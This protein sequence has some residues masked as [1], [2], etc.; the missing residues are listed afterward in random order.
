MKSKLGSIFLLLAATFCVAQNGKI[1]DI[2]PIT[3][4]NVSSAIRNVL[5]N[6]GY[7][8]LLD[9]KPFCQIWL[10]KGLPTQAKK[11]ATGAVYPQLTESTLVGVISF[12]Q[13]S[14]DYRGQAIAAGTY[15][16]R[17]ELIPSDGNHLGVSPNPDFLLLIPAGSDGD[18]NAVYKFDELVNLSRKATGTH[19]PAP[20]SMVQATRP[21]SAAISKDEED[22]WIFSATLKLASGGDL[23]LGLVVKG[24]ALQ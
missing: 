14:A 1:E 7:R 3:D 17:Y 18:P 15:T 9:G 8:A 24:T 6:K 13:G 4:S 16:L 10:R 23:P 19:H 5:E 22:H 21:D 12:P 11:E 2:G 20:L